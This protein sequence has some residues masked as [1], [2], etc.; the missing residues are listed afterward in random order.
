MLVENK[1]IW[2]GLQKFRW[3]RKHNVWH[4]PKEGYKIY[5]YL[6]GLNKKYAVYVYNKSVMC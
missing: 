4:L 3:K 1:S 6:T 2:D 5:H